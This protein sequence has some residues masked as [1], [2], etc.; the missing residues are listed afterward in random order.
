MVAFLSEISFRVIS[1]REEK[2]YD[3]ILNPSCPSHRLTIIVVGMAGKGDNSD[4]HTNY[5]EMDHY[6]NI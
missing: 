5:E 2:H 4:Q 6:N 1:L 3:L